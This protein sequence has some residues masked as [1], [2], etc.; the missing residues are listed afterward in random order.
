MLHLNYLLMGIMM[1]MLY[2]NYFINNDATV[3][4]VEKIEL[5]AYTDQSIDILG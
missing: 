3:E 2:L 5:V 1:L 4:K